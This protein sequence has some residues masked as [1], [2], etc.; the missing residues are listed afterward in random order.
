MI[1]SW[2]WRGNPLERGRLMMLVYRV[3]DPD[4]DRVVDVDFASRRGVWKSEEQR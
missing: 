2:L 3:S 1:M 4:N